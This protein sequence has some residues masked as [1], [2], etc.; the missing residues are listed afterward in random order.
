MQTEHEKLAD[1]IIQAEV[2]IIYLTYHRNLQLILFI[3]I[4][5]LL[6]WK[7]LKNYVQLTRQHVL[8]FV[9]YM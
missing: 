1:D 7:I 4:L 5:H 6:T 9:S 3:Y 2:G 8:E